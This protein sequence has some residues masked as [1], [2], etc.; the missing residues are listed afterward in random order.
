MLITPTIHA[1]WLV[2]GT[3]ISLKVTFTKKDDFF[4][5]KFLHKML[6]LIFFQCF[7]HKKKIN[8]SALSLLKCKINHKCIRK[9]KK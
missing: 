4:F 5:V 6:T 9:K 3:N 1:K 8:V 7:T 2:R